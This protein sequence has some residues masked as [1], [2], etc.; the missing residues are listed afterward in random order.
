MS[1]L[2]GRKRRRGWDGWPVEPRRLPNATALDVIPEV[3]EEPE[4]DFLLRTADGRRVD[5]DGGEYNV[6]LNQLRVEREEKLMD[7]RTMVFGMGAAG[8]LRVGYVLIFRIF[9][10]LAPSFIFIS[11]SS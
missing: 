6:G 7:V 3:D 10:Y 11:L 8:D 5:T 9:L 2:A 1:R 4:D